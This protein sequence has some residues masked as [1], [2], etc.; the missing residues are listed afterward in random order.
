MVK[1]NFTQGGANGAEVLLTMGIR[2]IILQILIAI[3]TGDAATA[4]QQTKLALAQPGQLARLAKRKHT[5]RIEG[6]CQFSQKLLLLLYLRQMN[7]L[8]DRIWNF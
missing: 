4:Q 1:I 8:S 2:N 7:G 6:H 5:A 3:V